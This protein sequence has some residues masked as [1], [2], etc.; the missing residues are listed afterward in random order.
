M[1]VDQDGR[2]LSKRTAE[3]DE[4][5]LRKELAG[6]SPD[7]REALMLML[8][9]LEEEP[10]EGEKQL[11]QLVS[12]AEWKRV[13]VDIETFVKDEYYLGNTCA[14]LY[15]QLLEDMKELFEGGEYQEAVLTGSIGYGKCVDP[16]TEIFDPARGRRRAGDLGEDWSVVSMDQDTGK[17][18][19]SSAS[20]FASG[21]KE[22]IQLRLAGGQRID[23]SYDHPV[24]TAR[25]WVPAA[26][27]R[28]DDLVA[29]PRRLPGPTTP[30]EISDDEV[31]LVAYLAGDGGCTGNTTFTNM[32]PGVLQEFSEVALVCADTSQYDRFH[33]HIEPEVTV[34]EGANSG[35]ATTLQVKGIRHLVKRHGMD[36][37]AKEKRVPAEFYLL[38]DRQVALFLNRFW[39]CDGSIG[40]QGPWTVETTLASEGLVDDLRFLLLRLGV[41]SRKCFNPKK[42]EKK[43]YDAWTLSISGADN[44]RAFLEAVGP[45][46]SKEEACAVAMDRAVSTKSNTNVDIVPVGIEELREIRGELGAQG[47]RLTQDFGCPAGQRLS[48]ERFRRLVQER[49]YSGK[50]AWLADTDILWERVRELKQLEARPV[51]D[52]S[53]PGDTNFVA[54]GIVIHNTFFASIGI[55]RILYELSCM[56]DPHR[57][58]GL[59]P[60][61]DI[62]I[63]CLSVN[64][65]LAMKVAFDNVATKLKA[66][67]YFEEHFPFKS[68]KK[69]FRFPHNVW[70]AARATTD[71]SALGLNVIG[72]LLDETNFMD[73]GRKVDPR[74]GAV[75]HAE[76]LYT[77]IMRR[78]KSRFGR[79]GKL[80]GMIFLVSSK[81][82]RDDFT[83]RRIRESRNDP[84]VF[85]R[86]YALWDVK[87]SAYYSSKKFFVICGNEQTPSRILQ[88]DEEQQV[89]SQLPDD[90]TLIEVPEDF[91]FDFEHDLEGCLT[92]DTLIP[93]LDGTEAR[94]EDLVGREEFWTYSYTPDG[95]FC[96]GRGSDARLTRKNAKLVQVTLDNGEVVRCTS[97]HPFMLRSGEYK[98]A[99][100]LQP[101][102]S[103]MP[104]YW[105]RDR[106]GYELI[107]SNAGGKWIHTHRLVA[108]EALNEGGALSS[109]LV[110]HHRNFDRLDNS[111]WNLE[112][113]TEAEHAELHRRYLHEGMLSEESKARAR[114]G[115]KARREANPE[116]ARAKSLAA[117]KKASEVYNSD[118]Y[119]HSE[120]ARKVGKTYGWGAENPSAAIVEARSRNGTKNITRLNKSDQNPARKPANRAA[121][122]ARLAEAVR[123]DPR[124]RVGRI[125]GLHTRWHTGPF[126]TCPRCQESLRADGNNHK[127]VSVEPAGRAD[128]YDITVEGVHNFALSAGVVVHNSIR[129]IAGV[130][131]VAISPFIQR[132]EK[133]VFNAERRHPFSVEIYD[134]SRP[135]TFLWDLMVRKMQMKDFSGHVHEALKP[136]VNPK[137]PRHIHID[138]AYRKDAVGICMSHIS[139]WTDVVRRAED[140]SVF[141]ERQPRFFVDLILQVV[142]PVGD[143]I[144]LGDLRRLVYSLSDHGYMITLVTMDTWQSVDSLQQLKQKGYAAEHLSVDTKMDPYEHLKSAFYE[145]RVDLYNYPRLFKE[146][147]ELEKDEKKKKVD[148]PPR[149]SK[150]IADALA[151][152]LYTLAKHQATQPLP[153]LSGLSYSPDAWMEEQLHAA[154]AHQRGSQGAPGNRFYPENP[155]AGAG[156][157]YP[158]QVLPPVLGGGPN[159]S[160]GG[161]GPDW[162]GGW[163]PSS[164]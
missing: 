14:V 42:I 27:L 107:K 53:V 110:V 147:R 114:A 54:N 99:G 105:R 81:K 57:S 112:V 17:L 51:V 162:G 160:P 84:H 24:F 6:L 86:D 72:S 71:S 4:D 52:L 50:Y 134:P 76:M 65:A 139:G 8:A 157:G 102:D 38:P 135:G 77:G 103:L 30:L 31:K 7:E 109:A 111:P 164:L 33:R 40:V 127:V 21:T 39:A 61:T 142:P 149:G 100:E 88:K 140:G 90:V 12:E 120:V 36:S 94:I 41:L 45:V 82:T 25:G 96:P 63:V 66:S 155:Q 15:P 59:A 131:T 122:A 20:A 154:A 92:G 115:R 133:L 9:E 91:R 26:K 3:E 152:C 125:K 37:R 58:L 121:S 156:G 106:Y 10:E 44:V 55:C 13:P 123:S 144:V 97:N 73:R 132:R 75:D 46:F 34:A 89:K 138:P 68:T 87:P 79:S 124:M 70:L 28:L 74:H 43:K 158:L 80:P 150:D 56:N 143:E 67:P 137:A 153:I 49:D 151:G 95:R 163:N 117:L 5:T 16:D 145:D 29:T 148:H 85:V 11:I 161:G 159:G 83:A 98:E 101:D 64:E 60:D 23:L 113:M 32:D 128:V 22:C 48:R 126:E 141:Q 116:E 19:V 69:E 129:D 118:A 35:Q 136:I 2:S 130:A 104:L 47:A 93:L 1:I 119:D 18:C 108:R 146:L 62:S 78:M